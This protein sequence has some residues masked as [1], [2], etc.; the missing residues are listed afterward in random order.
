MGRPRTKNR[1]LPPRMYWKNGAYFYV[2]NQN[3]WIRL[4]ADIDEAKR[5]WVELEAPCRLPSQGMSAVFNRYAVEVLPKKAKKTREE[6]T[7]QMKLLEAAF[8]DFRP[9][10]VKPVHVAQYLDA[11][12]DQG[13]AV[14][15]NREKS[16]L[17]HVF[18]M[19]M[20][21]G[22]VEVNPCKGVSRNKEKPR[23]RYV[24]DDEFERFIAFCR[25]LKHGMLAVRKDGVPAPT[26]NK[27]YQEPLLSGQI[28]ATAM[29]IAYLAAQRRQDILQLTM[30]NIHPEGLLVSQLKGK[31]RKPVKVMVSWAPRLA[32]AIG[33]AQSLWR[34]KNSRHLFVSGRTGKPYT[35]SGFNALV[36]KIQRAWEG[37]GNPRFHFHDLRAKGTTDLLDQGEDAK[38]T[39][40]HANDAI[41]HAVYDRRAIRKG[42]AVK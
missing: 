16:L 36:Q 22:I 4:S 42:K 21:W 15:G 31:D 24:S 14:A 2:T 3:K 6:Q 9:D 5:R 30:D 39:T 11:R 13:A 27:A 40:G 20:R 12:A 32:E 19:A 33:R 38:N 10:E 37:A 34:P 25:G 29:E 23:D 28:V 26:K 35:D 17:S 8:A 1:D 7:R 41:V 18:T